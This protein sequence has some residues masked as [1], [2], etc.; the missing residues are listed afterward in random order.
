MKNFKKEEI[1]ERINELLK[2]KL[3]YERNIFGIQ[4]AIQ[5]LQ[6]LTQEGEA[7]DVELVQRSN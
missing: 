1:Q 7:N 6:R 3:E 2:M 5:E 4:G